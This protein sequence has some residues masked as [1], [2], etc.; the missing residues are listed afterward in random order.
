MGRWRPKAKK[1]RVG[2]WWSRRVASRR[3]FLY[4]AETPFVPL[5]F[6]YYTS[7]PCYRAFIMVDS[8]ATTVKE[9][10]PV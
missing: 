4:R 8:T 2:L 10:P 3:V 6:H 5:T 9:G 7:R 1:K